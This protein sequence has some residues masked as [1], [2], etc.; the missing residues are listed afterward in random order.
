MTAHP[1]CARI[2]ASRNATFLVEVGPARRP[3]QVDGW[4]P[5]ATLELKDDDLADIVAAI[6]ATGAGTGAASP[7][8]FPASPRREL[9]ASWAQPEAQPWV[10]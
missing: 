8:S 4:L 10:S 3:G 5:A 6:R 2:A 1:P 7:S 9:G